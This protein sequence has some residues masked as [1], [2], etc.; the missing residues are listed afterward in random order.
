MSRGSKIEVQ[1]TEVRHITQIYAWE[2]PAYEHI[3]YWLKLKGA[4]F[5]YK[6]VDGFVYPHLYAF[7]KKNREQIAQELADEAGINFSFKEF[8]WMLEQKGDED[9]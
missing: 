9:E 8:E 2:E 5:R 6:S 3:N 7:L 4:S 1:P